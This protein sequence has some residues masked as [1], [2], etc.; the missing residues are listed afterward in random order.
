MLLH[1]RQFAAGPLC[2]IHV[3]DPRDGTPIVDADCI[4]PF[5]LQAAHTVE[6]DP[7]TALSTGKL[8]PVKG[9]HHDH[10]AKTTKTIGEGFDKG[11][12]THWSHLISRQS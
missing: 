7:Q 5:V 1:D 2:R 9:T 4:C 11:Y 8:L 10:A 6:L 3:L 12:G